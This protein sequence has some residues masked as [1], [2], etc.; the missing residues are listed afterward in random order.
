MISARSIVRSCHALLISIIPERNMV[1]VDDFNAGG[2]TA[3]RRP[4]C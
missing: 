4:V 2:R 3:L 1:M